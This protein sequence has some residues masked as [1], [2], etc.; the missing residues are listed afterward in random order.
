M[1]QY[2]QSHTSYFIFITTIIKHLRIIQYF[3]YLIRKII[4]YHTAF[5]WA[6]ESMN[7]I[8]YNFLLLLFRVY[9][10]T[11]Q[12]PIALYRMVLY[13][14]ISFSMVTSDSLSY[15]NLDLQH[16]YKRIV[17]N[18]CAFM[19]SLCLLIILTY[20]HQTQGN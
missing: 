9:M 8:I 18:T 20:S 14:C 6:G 5:V 2:F 3:I 16:C 12:L 13:T 4:L 19:V 10:Y 17:H 1:Y 15:V 7:I 11:S